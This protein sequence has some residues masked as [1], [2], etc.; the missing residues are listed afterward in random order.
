MAHGK[1]MV[2]FGVRLSAAGALFF[3]A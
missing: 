2:L 1:M 3:S